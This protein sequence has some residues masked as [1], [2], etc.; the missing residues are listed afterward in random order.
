MKDSVDDRMIEKIISRCNVYPKQ[1]PAKIRE[2]VK[3]VALLTDKE[4]ETSPSRR[5]L[6]RKTSK[7]MDMK[8]KIENDDWIKFEQDT[9]ELEEFR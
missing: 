3:K 8:S 6:I 2:H 1:N 5:R 4:L 9:I 7:A